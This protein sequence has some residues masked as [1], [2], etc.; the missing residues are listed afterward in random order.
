MDRFEIVIEKPAPLRKQEAPAP[1]A[2]AL[3]AVLKRDDLRLNKWNTLRGILRRSS[4]RR[5]RQV[6]DL[7]LY[8]PGFIALAARIHRAGFGYAFRCQPVLAFKYLGR[9]LANSFDTAARLRIMSHHYRT[10]AARLPDLGELGFPWNEIVLWSHRVELDTFTI[11]LCMPANH[12]LEGELSLVFSVNGVRLHKLSF[13]CI[14]G[15]EVGVEAESALLVGGS[16]GFPGAT[17][18][19]RQASKA[20]G[21]ISPAAML[22]LS[23]QALA[24]HLGADAIFGISADEQT[25]LCAE[26][27]QAK[28]RY[29]ALW[30]M[31]GGERQ[32]RFYRLPSAVVWKDTSHLSNSHR[33]RARRKRELKER[34]LG[35]IRKNVERLFS[36]A[37]RLPVFLLAALSIA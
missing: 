3:P 37:D 17:A 36:V 8:L 34:I 2:P 7:G 1:E 18:L 14:P 27:E 19:I 26:P 20:I 32:G 13:T 33:A 23:L 11:G 35:Q 31:M 29:D 4:R 25:S 10:L 16:Q 28:S 6:M 15:K 9:Y 30:E 12:Y 22:I 5:A 21:E 24:K